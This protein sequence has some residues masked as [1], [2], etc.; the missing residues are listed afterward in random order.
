MREPI[1]IGEVAELI[2]AEIVG[3]S[4]VTFASIGSLA[5]AGKKIFLTYQVIPIES[6]C[7][8]R[9]LLLLYCK[10]RNWTVVR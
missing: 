3:D 10:E 8:T 7:R 6:F 9:K 2:G 1:K 4:S 5:S